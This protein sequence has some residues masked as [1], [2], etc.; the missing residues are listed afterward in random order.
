MFYDTSASSTTTTAS[1]SDPAPSEEAKGEA[2]GPDLSIPPATGGVDGDGGLAGADQGHGPL[3]M[4]AGDW[5]RP[6]RDGE[7]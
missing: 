5:N 4:I 1:E 3:G 2:S 6:A 7:A